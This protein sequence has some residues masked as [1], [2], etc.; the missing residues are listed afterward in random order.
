LPQIF[1]KFGENA[2]R[3]SQREKKKILTLPD[4]FPGFRIDRE[5]AM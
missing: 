3:Q 5:S 4:S 1:W 2:D